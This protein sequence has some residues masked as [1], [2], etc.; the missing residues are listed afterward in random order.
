MSQIWTYFS[1]NI[2]AAFST[3]RSI[4]FSILDIIV[5][6]LLIYALI[7]FLKKN[8]A[9]RLIKYLTILLVFGAIAGSRIVNMPVAGKV[10]G[11]TLLLLVLAVLILFAPNVKR[12]L[13]KLA[14][15]KS[16]QTSYNTVYDCSASSRV[17][18]SRICSGMLSGAI[19]IS[20]PTSFLDI[21]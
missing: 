8:N 10:F 12:I 13:W 7:V 17:P 3:P 4:I 15:P 1:Y 9:E 19:M 20:A 18:L 2:K 14:S 6:I 21:Y 16:A 5:T 11:N